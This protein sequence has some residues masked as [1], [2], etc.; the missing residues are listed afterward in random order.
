MRRAPEIGTASAATIR[1]TKRANFIA[2]VI[3]LLVS[4]N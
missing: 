1:E 4:Y 2:M 3:L